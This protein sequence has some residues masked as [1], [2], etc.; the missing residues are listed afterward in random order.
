MS[1][2]GSN[3]KVESFWQPVKQKWEMVLTDEGI[4][5]DG[6]DLQSANA[7]RPS[8]KTLQPGS[9]VN[10]ERLVQSPKQHREIF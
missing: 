8:L 4:Q 6:S 9:N 3:V 10:L 1:Q 5:T 7:A 2:P